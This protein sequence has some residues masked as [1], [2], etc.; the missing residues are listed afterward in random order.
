MSKLDLSDPL[1]ELTELEKEYVDYL[2]SEVKLNDAELQAKF[3][4][5]LQSLNSKLELRRIVADFKISRSRRAGLV[6]L[7]KLEE[8]TKTIP[9]CIKTLVDIM[10]NG[11]EHNKVA[12]ASKLITPALSYLDKLG[13]N[14]AN[15]ESLENAS[16][17]GKDII[18][19][20]E[21]QDLGL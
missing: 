16:E 8:I 10:K 3:G 4:D 21:K 14:V 18:I 6:D 17:L 2:L 9:L 12:A 11:K 15:V 7:Y 13:V 5:N 19:Q 20:A 1:K